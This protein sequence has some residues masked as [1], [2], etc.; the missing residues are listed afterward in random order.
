MYGKTFLVEQSAGD[1]HTPSGGCSRPPLHRQS[2][3]SDQDQELKGVPVQQNG[4]NALDDSRFAVCGRPSQPEGA[5]SGVESPA[6]RN[7]HAHQAT[8]EGSPQPIPAKGL[9]T[10]SPLRL[11]A[12]DDLEATKP[13]EHSSLFAQVAEDTHV[14]DPE[15]RASGPIQPKRRRFSFV[16][17][18]P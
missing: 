16:A 17:S 2:L 7:S 14:N 1:Q 12:R 8:C 3:A 6:A 5:L 10:L 15:H 13:K 18:T 11:R 9:A 4:R